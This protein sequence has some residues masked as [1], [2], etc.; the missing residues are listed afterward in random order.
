MEDMSGKSNDDMQLWYQNRVTL[1][2]FWFITVCFHRGGTWWREFSYSFPII[3]MSIKKFKWWFTLSRSI[4]YSFFHYKFFEKDE[5]KNL[6]NLQNFNKSLLHAPDFH[7]VFKINLKSF[8]GT[9]S[10]CSNAVY[11]VNQCYIALYKYSAITDRNSRSYQARIQLDT[12]HM[13]DIN[14]NMFKCQS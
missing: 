13:I 10:T 8:Q 7:R 14:L 4:I 9:S 5:N 6:L 12:W 1:H 2:L 11:I 3:P